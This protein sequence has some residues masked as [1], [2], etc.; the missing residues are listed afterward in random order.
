MPSQVTSLWSNY[1]ILSSD[2]KQQMRV[3]VSF[4]S[5]FS[6]ALY[7]TNLTTSNLCSINK[8]LCLVY[9]VAFKLVK[10]FNLNGPVVYKKKQYIT[11]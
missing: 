5:S 10:K 11:I 9:C 3:N 4:D 8:Y 2:T 1:L 7:S 6:P